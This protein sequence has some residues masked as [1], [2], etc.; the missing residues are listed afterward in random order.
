MEVEAAGV[1]MAELVTSI[2]CALVE[3]PE[4][5]AVRLA[6]QNECVVLNIMAAPADL[7]RIIG[8]S[9]QTARAL[10]VILSS[11]STKL[12]VRCELNIV[13]AAVEALN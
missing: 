7:G 4:D 12:K 1:E 2:V 6:K 13:A 3:R 5:V 11:V 9:G 10:R 8:R